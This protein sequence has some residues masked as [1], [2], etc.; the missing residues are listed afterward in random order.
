M[1]ES[2]LDYQRWEKGTGARFCSRLIIEKNRERREN[3]RKVGV[4]GAEAP[5]EGG[6]GEAG[7]LRSEGGD[8]PPLI[9]NFSVRIAHCG[10]SRRVGVFMLAA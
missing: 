1:E 2:W 7:R 5:R 8:V 6:S 3:T 10:A 4:L 9:T